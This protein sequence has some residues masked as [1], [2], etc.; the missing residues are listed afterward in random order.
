ML[1]NAQLDNEGRMLKYQTDLLKDELE[2]ANENSIQL[3]N[4]I[5][6]LKNVN[7]GMSDWV[8]KGMYEAVMRREGFT[9]W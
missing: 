6:K 4:K 9:L 8:Y 2:T 7:G 1:L 3:K 5:Q